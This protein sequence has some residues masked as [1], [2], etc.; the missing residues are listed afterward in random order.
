MYALRG[1]R[2]V[3]RRHRRSA[4]LSHDDAKWPLADYFVCA[5]PI[6]TTIG[7][8]RLGEERG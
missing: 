8:I 3:R 4:S 1:P 6:G 2:D 7:G 5:D